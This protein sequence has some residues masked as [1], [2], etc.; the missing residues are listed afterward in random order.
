MS[1]QQFQTDHW[2]FAFFS[3]KAGMVGDT[4]QCRASAE[5]WAQ[6]LESIG[7][8][9]QA[10]RLR[11]VLDSSGKQDDSSEEEPVREIN[12]EELIELVWKQNDVVLACRQLIADEYGEDHPLISRIDAI[13][14]IEQA[15][16]R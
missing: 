3:I 10:V 12:R 13:R 16:E 1:E 11:A 6:R 4:E 15:G 8:V 5:A 9:R 2:S 14:L 7:A